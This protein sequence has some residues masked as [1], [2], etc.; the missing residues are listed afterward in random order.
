[1]DDYQEPPKR[2]R[3][4]RQEASSRKKAKNDN[5]GKGNFSGLGAKLMQK[6][7]WKEGEGL[8][9]DGKGIQSAISVKVRNTKGGVG[10]IKEKTDQVIQEEKRRKRREAEERGEKYVDSSEEERAQRTQR[11]KTASASASGRGTPRPKKPIY[12]LEAAGFSVPAQ[13]QR[14]VDATGAVLDTSALRLRGTGQAFQTSLTG[15]IQRELDAFAD[16]AEAVDSEAKNIELEVDRLTTELNKL[17]VDIGE[18]SDIYSRLDELRSKNWS[19]VIEGLKALHKAYPSRDFEKEAIATIRPSFEKRIA[20]WDPASETLEELANSLEE[21]SI[22]HN[23]STKSSAPGR[24]LSRPVLASIHAHDGPV[25]RRSTTPF[26]SLMLK[27]FTHLQMAMV[28]GFKPDKP[29]AHTFIEAIEA[30]LPILPIFIKGRI[31]KEI[32]IRCDAA[33][34]KWNARKLIKD[35]SAPLPQWIFTYLPYYP[36][37]ISEAKPKVRTAVDAWEYERGVIPGI[38]LWKSF[39]EIKELLVRHVLPRLSTRLRDNLEIDPTDQNLQP[40]EEVLAWT[41]VIP[42]AHIA[43]L[44]NTRF[45]PK[46]YSTLHEWLRYEEANM[47]EI[48]QWLNWWRHDVFPAEIT[49]EPVIQAAWDKAFNLVNV[50]LDLDAKELD[51]L[52]LPTNETSKA[53]SPEAPQ[54]SK[55]VNAEPPKPVHQVEEMAFKDV[56]EAWCAEENLLLIPLRKADEKTGFPLFRITASATGKGGIVIYFKGDI[57]YAQ[58]KKDKSTWDPVGLDEELVS[59]A[60][61][62]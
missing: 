30:W 28:N 16:E 59:R 62:K 32:K 33:L 44:L 43:E 35:K 56:V 61:G 20:G 42:M 19:E 2:K 39:P 55:S 18:L 25:Y 13:L 48:S 60:E 24:E 57:V 27:W 11:K 17:E 9:K 52:P 38:K 5:E 6:M 50:A 22:I 34:K 8:G 47:T 15:R 3:T 53:P 37:I 29:S 21:L 51:T 4:F 14:I 41:E 40:I 46:F 45:F 26:E 49:D 10:I 36:D 54:L 7:G 12:D 58:N 23:S 1:M 31:N